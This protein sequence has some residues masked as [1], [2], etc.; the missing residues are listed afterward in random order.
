MFPDNVLP[1]TRALA[2]DLVAEG[3]RGSAVRLVRRATGASTKEAREYV[4][5]LK[6]EVLARSV[7]A[8]TEARAVALVAQGK[9]IDAAKEVRQ[10][11]PLGLKDAKEYVDGLR[12]GIL[13]PRGRG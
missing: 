7:P 10:S 5:R 1:E 9:W 2:L 6:A 13:R 3:N 4:D 11:T 12:S 8:E